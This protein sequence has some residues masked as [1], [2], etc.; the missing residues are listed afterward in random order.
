MKPAKD[1][2]NF[3]ISSKI[4]AKFYTPSFRNERSDSSC[5]FLQLP[6]SELLFGCLNLMD[7]VPKRQLQPFM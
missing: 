5:I 7:S 2:I 1:T 6:L 4:V 3:N